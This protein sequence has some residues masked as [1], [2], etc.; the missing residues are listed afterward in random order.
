T[1]Y[2]AEDTFVAAFAMNDAGDSSANLPEDADDYDDVERDENG[3]YPGDGIH[4]YERMIKRANTQYEL[5][6]NCYDSAR[7]ELT[8]SVDYR[9]IYVSFP[10]FKIDPE[11]ISPHEVRYYDPDSVDEDIENC[12]LCEP[13][14]GLGMLSGSIEDSVGLI[15]SEGNARDV[16]DTRSFMDFLEDPLA[17]GLFDLIWVLF[18][19]RELIQEDRVCHLE[20]IN[21]LPVGRGEYL[22]PHGKAVTEIL[23]IQILKIG[24]FAIAAL[25]FEVTTMGGRRIR[26]DIKRI[27]DDVTHVEI[28]AISNA[29]MGYLTTRDEYS[30]QHYEGG[31]NWFG[32]YALNGIRQMLCELA[33]TFQSGVDLPEYSLTINEIR[34]TLEHQKIKVGK[35]CFDS[36]P[37]G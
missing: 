11:Y 14:A 13:V 33:S 25:P 34:N 18:M 28:N 15:D 17:N 22:I 16:T 10:N 24:R 8:G 26:D 1:D 29:Y 27:L 21:A 4:D 31:A 23:P 2:L 30:I 6:R 12:R 9:Q 3:N 19:P 5:A 32:P 36:K 20:K 37:V 35:V 7:E